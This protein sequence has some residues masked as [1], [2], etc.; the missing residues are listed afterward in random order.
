MKAHVMR[1]PGS[2]DNLQLTAWPDPK[3]A[4]GKILIAV[5]AFGLN[6]SELMTIQGH[7]GEAVTYPRV[8]GIEC[9]GEVLDGGG[10]RPPTR[11]EGGRRHGLYGPSVRRGLRGDSPDPLKTDLNWPN[12]GPS[13][14]PPTIR[15]KGSSSWLQLRIRDR[16][17]DI[18]MS[19][20]KGQS[21]TIQA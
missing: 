12:L 3:P 5:K 14:P 11:P 8:L 6:R 21:L 9:V 2:I 4:P 16:S 19:P 15:R 17:G 10:D 7:S 20:R 18:M 13:P 1:E